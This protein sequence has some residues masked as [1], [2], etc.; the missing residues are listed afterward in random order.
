MRYLILASLLLACLASVPRAQ[1]ADS[2]KAREKA[3]K[4]ACAA[5]DFHKGV[6]ILAGLYVDSNT[7]TYIYNQARCYEQNHQWVGAIDR[8]R[9]YLRKTPNASASDKADVDKHI[10]ECEAFLE[11]EQSKATAS[12][13]AP[14]PAPL[15]A[16][17]APSPPMSPAPVNIAV[18]APAPTEGNNGA[19]LRVAGIVVGSAGVVALLTGLIL[20][21]KAN[22]LADDFN[23]TQDPSTRSSQ[24]S[25]KTASMICYGAG[26]G[27]LVA[28]SVMYLIGRMSADAKPVQ[29]SFVSF[30]PVLTPGEFSLHLRRTF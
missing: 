11:K 29:V 6:E 26:A 1:A 12:P 21:M 23:N 16:A 22:S 8:F 5:G 3:A 27:V 7:T 17:S 24:S 18:P 4:M 19:G 2:P 30:L 15:P 25:Y 28:G 10:A 9:E 20:N 14:A 13:A